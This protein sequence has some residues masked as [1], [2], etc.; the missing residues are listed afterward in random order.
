MSMKEHQVQLARL[1]MAAYAVGLAL[2][3]GWTVGADDDADGGDAPGNGAAELGAVPAIDDTAGQVPAEVQ[4]FA[5]GQG[6][7][8][9]GQAWADPRKRADRRKQWKQ[10]IRSQ[11]L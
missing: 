10:D 11:G 3:A 4:D 5:A 8:E 1:V 9:L 6:V 7:E 2:V